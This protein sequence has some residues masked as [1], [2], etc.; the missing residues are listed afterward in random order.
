MRI[1]VGGTRTPT[2]ISVGIDP[3]WSGGL[4]CLWEDGTVIGACPMPETPRDILEVLREFGIVA[5]TARATIRAL[6]ERAQPFPGQGVVSVG[7]YLR[8]YGQLEM[9]L[10]A[11]GIPFDTI[12]ALRWMTALQCRT[13]GDKNITKARAQALF[14]DLRVTHALADALLIAEYGR[15]LYRGLLAPRSQTNGEAK[16]RTDQ[17]QGQAPPGRKEA[18][19]P[20]HPSPARASRASSANTAGDGARSRQPTR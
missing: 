8:N 14:P 20:A 4:A 12:T 17:G 13:R 5:H 3:G 16:G 11:A 10:T 18:G 15:R 2:T 7:T 1:H 9:A 6:L 19:A